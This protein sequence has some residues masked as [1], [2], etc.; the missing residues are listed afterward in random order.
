MMYQ[1]YNIAGD[2]QDIEYYWCISGACQH[3][4]A[5]ISNV[6]SS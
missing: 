4:K 3:N 1:W 2:R 6:V 5:I